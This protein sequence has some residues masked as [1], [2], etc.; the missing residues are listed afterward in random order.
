MYFSE[1]KDNNLFI[2]FFLPLGQLNSCHSEEN[3]AAPCHLYEMSE[4]TKI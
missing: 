4:N 1:F 2:G 3:F